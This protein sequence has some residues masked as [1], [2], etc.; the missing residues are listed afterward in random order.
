MGHPYFVKNNNLLYPDLSFTIN[1]VLYSVHNELGRYCREKQYCNKLEERLK[2]K[3][4]KHIREYTIGKTGNI[5]D[6]EI[7]GKILIEV[8]AKLPMVKDHYFQLQRYLQAADY[9]LGILVNFRYK[10]IIPMRVLKLETDARKHSP[11]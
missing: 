2:E 10:K 4:I 1:G 7:E 6:F 11:V 5:A 8:K 9:E 3:G